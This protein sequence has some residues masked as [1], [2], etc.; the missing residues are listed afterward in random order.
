LKKTLSINDDDPGYI[1]R[2]KKSILDDLEKRIE[3]WDMMSSLQV[4]TALD[5]RFKKL[6][7]FAGEMREVIWNMVE[8]QFDLFRQN[9]VVSEGEV[10]TAKGHKKARFSIAVESESDE[11]ETEVRNFE[12]SEYKREVQ[13]PDT[14]NPLTWWKLNTHRYPMLSKFAKV[15]LCIPATSVPCERLFSSSGYI[16]N[17]MRSSL[18]PE[19]VRTLVCLRDWLE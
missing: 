18:L 12:I 10:T 15:M 1:A 13:I 16:V 19:N 7:C 4:A 17:K 2:L 11:E 14:E 5:P 6:K 3:D 9:Q 8:K